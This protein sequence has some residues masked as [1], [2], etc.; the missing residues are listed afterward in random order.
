[1]T[2]IR[3]FLRKYDL[4]I[5]VPSDAG[6][7]LGD[8]VWD[9]VVGPPRPDKN[10]APTNV[11]NAFEYL[12][13]IDEA[14]RKA[15]QQQARATQLEAAGLPER[16]ITVEFQHVGR[17]EFPGI[18]NLETKIEVERVLEFSFGD[19]QVRNMS[20]DMRLDIA[21]RLDGIR[22]RDWKRYDMRVRRA[23]VITELYYG[24]IRI[25]LDLQVRS[26]V[27]VAVL[28]AAGFELESH[29]SLLR[30][31]VFKMDVQGVPFAMQTARLLDI[32]P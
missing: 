19:L 15:C 9:P 25:S 5:I 2:T 20:H 24:S 3:Q 22:Q 26:E 16:A 17:L 18:A 21:R 12:G 14:T 4:D 1:M 27:D 23:F 7:S 28:Q 30:K 6:I 31:E 29:D 8:M 32:V 13:E 10:G 11:F